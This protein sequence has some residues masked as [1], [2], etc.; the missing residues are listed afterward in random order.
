MSTWKKN[1]P[2]E[3]LVSM[4]GHGGGF[5][6]SVAGSVVTAAGRR[7]VI[8][9]VRARVDCDYEQLERKRGRQKNDFWS[10]RVRCFLKSEFCMADYL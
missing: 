10:R 3:V 5:F 6:A 8:R 1:L 2:A 9:C 7:D 4:P